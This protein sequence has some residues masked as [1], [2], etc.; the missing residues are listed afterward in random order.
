MAFKWI[1]LFL[2]IMIGKINSAAE[3]E[4][5]DNN[6]QAK[7]IKRLKRNGCP[8]T[9]RPNDMP[10]WTL[11]KQNSKNVKGVCIKRGYRVTE[12]PTGEANV[13]TVY[14]TFYR[15]KVLEVDE[16]QKTVTIDL[17]L[18]S[19]WED[20]RIKT[21]FLTGNTEIQLD[22]TTSTL[23]IWNPGRS[24]YIANLKERKLLY[25]PIAISELTFLSNNPFN[26]S[27]D[28]ALVKATFEWRVTVFCE[29][30]FLKFPLDNQRCE[31][32]SG[33]KGSGDIKSILYAPDDNKNCHSEKPFEADGYNMTIVFV[34]STQ[35]DENG[36]NEFGFDITMQRQIQ[37]YLFQYYLP[38][39]SIVVVSCISFIVPLTAIPGRI[40]L[41]VTQFLTL[42][43]I[44]IHQMVSNVLPNI[45]IDLTQHLIIYLTTKI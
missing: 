5:N 12:A 6:E 27:T 21:P 43:N 44:F 2:I 28:T 10:K 41:V 9:K 25:D 7:E 30:N 45:P 38:C 8:M 23:P 15:T 42:T 20:D 40:A 29:F 4:N 35:L 24:T 16:T 26:R 22:T 3:E 39:I 11:M 37:P 13:T 1:I 31:L 14:K 34:G 19:I 17:K 32:R 33:S 36:T 18:S